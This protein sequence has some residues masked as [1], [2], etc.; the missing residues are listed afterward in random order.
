MSYGEKYTSL[1]KKFVSYYFI[2]IK[3]KCQCEFRALNVFSD[4]NVYKLGFAG[5]EDT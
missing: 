5:K 4:H 2:P 3:R 1:P